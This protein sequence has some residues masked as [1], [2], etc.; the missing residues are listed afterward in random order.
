MQW[1]FSSV[2]SS[3]HQDSKDTSEKNF[4]KPETITIAPPCKTF[5]RFS[6]NVLCFKLV[7]FLRWCSLP[8]HEHLVLSTLELSSSEDLTNRCYRMFSIFI[9]ISDRKRFLRNRI[10]FW[11]RDLSYREPTQGIS[12]QP[13]L[14]P[15]RRRKLICV[16]TTASWLMVLRGCVM[17]LVWVKLWC[18]KR[19]CSVLDQTMFVLLFGCN[20]N[21]Y[22]CCF[23]SL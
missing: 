16:V 21:S 7:M 4:C 10:F 11:Y 23:F 22:Y 6:C 1:T 8:L 18:K 3:V 9:S 15:N 2:L 13:E 14:I 19:G 17:P 5:I 12:S 20:W